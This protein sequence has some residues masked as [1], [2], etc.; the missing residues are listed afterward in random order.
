MIGNATEKLTTETGR[1]IK[2]IEK[3]EVAV[4][5]CEGELSEFEKRYRETFEAWQVKSALSAGEIPE[6]RELRKL[7]ERIL[8]RRARHTGL[9]RHMVDLCGALSPLAERLEPVVVEERQQAL[10]RFRSKL[11]SSIAELLAIAAEGIR[12]EKILGQKVLPDEDTLP[13]KSLRGYFFDR[14]D[15]VRAWRSTPPAEQL[16]GEYDAWQELRQA[17]RSVKNKISRGRSLSSKIKGEEKKTSGGDDS[18]ML[19]GY[20]AG[21][22]AGRNQQIQKGENQ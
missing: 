20:A 5:D 3:V 13:V 12:L 9:R 6:P 4:S 18:G 21:L 11:D 14:G 22:N 19:L 8:Q 15:G 10:T 2:E 1:Q 16:P 7:S 17:A